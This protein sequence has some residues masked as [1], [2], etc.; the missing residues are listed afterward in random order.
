MAVPPYSYL[1]SSR[2]RW[3]FSSGALQA[4]FADR[5]G[6]YRLRPIRMLT[7]APGSSAARSVCL[8]IGK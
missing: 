2:G 5:P 6:P 4:A 1:T 3:Q 7:T 8:P